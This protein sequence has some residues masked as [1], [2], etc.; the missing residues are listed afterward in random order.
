MAAFSR[1]VADFLRDIAKSVF[2]QRFP[3]EVL[4]HVNGVLQI[5]VE[6]KSTIIQYAGLEDLQ[7]GYKIWVK[8]NPEDPH[9]SYQYDGMRLEQ[10]TIHHSPAQTRPQVA[11]EAMASVLAPLQAQLDA[12]GQTGL[13]DADGNPFPRRSNL[14]ITGLDYVVIDD[15]ATDTS[16]VRFLAAGVTPEEYDA[17]IDYD[18]AILYEGVPP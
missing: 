13:V 3:A 2:P 10:G 5:I 7:P 17:A 18:D 1:T 16:E 8:R 11:P 12:V 4:S 6:G 9:G 15:E 14:K